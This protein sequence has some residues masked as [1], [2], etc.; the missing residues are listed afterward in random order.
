[1]KDTFALITNIIT[2]IVFFG[3]IIFAIANAIWKK[4]YEKKYKI[5]ADFFTYP[6]KTGVLF[7]AAIIILLNI[8]ILSTIYLNYKDSIYTFEVKGK[9]KPN[10]NMQE[11]IGKNT[12]QSNIKYN[13]MHIKGNIY[14]LNDVNALSEISSDKIKSIDDKSK[15]EEGYKLLRFEYSIDSAK[16]NNKTKV[17]MLQVQNNVKIS[18]II[19]F[20]DQHK[21]LEGLSVKPGY[22]VSWMLDNNIE[23]NTLDKPIKEYKN[24]DITLKAQKKIIKDIY[25][26]IRINKDSLL[27][28]KNTSLSWLTLICIILYIFVISIGIYLYYVKMVKKNN[29]KIISKKLNHLYMLTLLASN[30]FSCCIMLFYNRN[31][32]LYSK[33]N[34]IISSI[35]IITLAFSFISFLCKNKVKKEHCIYIFCILLGMII[36]FYTLSFLDIIIYILFNFYLLDIIADVIIQTLVV[37]IGLVI[38]VLSYANLFINSIILDLE[39]K[40]KL[41]HINNKNNYL[42]IPEELAVISEHDKKFLS[43]RYKAEKDEL[44]ELNTYEYWLVDPSDCT[45]KE[46]SFKRESVINEDIQLRYEAEKDN[47]KKETEEGYKPIR[48]DFNGGTKDGKALENITKAILVGSKLSDSVETIDTFGVF[49]TIGNSVKG[50]NK[51]VESPQSFKKYKDVAVDDKNETK[52]LYAYYNKKLVKNVNKCKE[53][54]DD[55]YK[56]VV[57]D[58]NGGKKC[59]KK[60]RSVKKEV[61]IGAKLSDAVATVKTEGLVKKEEKTSSVFRF[62]TE[63]K[64]GAKQYTDVTIDDSYETK[65]L[66]AYYDKE[67]VKDVVRDKKT[68]DDGYKFVIFD[69]NGGT[70]DGKE[71][72]NIKKEVLI[73]ARLSDAVASVKMDGIIKKS[74]DGKKVFGF[75][76]DSKNE[77]KE[78]NDIMFESK[79]R[80][81]TLYAYYDK[82]VVKDVVFN[83]EKTD[84]EK[85]QSQNKSQDGNKK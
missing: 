15:P 76:T 5:S 82:D 53:T 67:V 17:F 71:L 85:D 39:P 41:I 8:T 72:E 37:M 75:W 12:D 74:K 30:A 62:W 55:G 58:F 42:D 23:V 51:W 56:F 40:Y 65:T 14:Y 34:L 79:C 77:T 36:T 83:K 35:I 38:I 27:V 45:I 60:A 7:R 50:F 26:V 69:F 22:Y 78:Y 68:P 1:M 4:Q 10:L 54:P 70:K 81:K 24:D 13:L 2:L 32:S 3:T 48:F 84:E 64:K 19:N 33:N 61:L 16:D 47:I 28:F 73:G 18:D 43:V 29:K 63:A 25:H 21:K 9:F 49:K 57:F 31:Y 52:T 11:I 46:K 66:Y 59:I 6:N 20:V 44:I 80:T